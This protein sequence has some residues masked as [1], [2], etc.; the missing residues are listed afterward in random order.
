[1]PVFG[2]KLTSN[3]LKGLVLW[4]VSAMGWI[5]TDSSVIFPNI[6]FRSRFRG[7]IQ[8]EK[9]PKVA[10]NHFR[11]QYLEIWLKFL[12]CFCTK[13][14][15]LKSDFQISIFKVVLGH[16]RA[17]ERARFRPKTTLKIEIW[18][19][20]FNS[21]HLVQKHHKNFSQISK[22]WILKWFWATFGHLSSARFRPKTTLT[23][24]AQ[25]VHRRT[26]GVFHYF[27]STYA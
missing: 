25:W 7:Q 12:R 11:M 26:H 24:S 2:P 10:Q 19:S 14:G 1:M 16:F 23:L 13:W 21:P 8:V 20:D 22:Y 6:H 5:T 3:L 4:T 17:L 27:S 18:K 15:E 9:C